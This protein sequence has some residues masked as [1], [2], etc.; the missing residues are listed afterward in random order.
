MP[1]P[2]KIQ[3]APVEEST[4]AE[5]TMPAPIRE[6]IKTMSGFSNLEELR[7]ELPETTAAPAEEVRTRRRRRTKA[8]MEAARGG[9]ENM[10]DKRY[11]D[12]C[13]NMAAFGGARG[14]KNVFKT[15][16]VVTGKPEIELNKDEAKVWD[17]FFYVV[18]KK[19][20]LDVGKTWYLVTFGILT[21]MEHVLVRVW[22]FNQET[23]TASLFDFFGFGKKEDQT[24]A[25][26]EP[27]TESK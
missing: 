2:K 10:E 3:P 14:I 25:S 5:T 20:N 22:Q 16:A 21:L 13:A 24:V 27:A 7:S 26:E 1:R 4:S 9:S 18:S 11:A 6:Q 12:A 19:S 23:F 17:D 15:A 8:E